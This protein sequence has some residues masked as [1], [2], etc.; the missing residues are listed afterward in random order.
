MIVYGP[1]NPCLEWSTQGLHVADG[2]HSVSAPVSR[3]RSR[4]AAVVLSHRTRRPSTEPKWWWEPASVRELVATLT[5]VQRDV[6]AQWSV[7][8]QSRG[9]KPLCA[10]ARA[11][12]PRGGGDTQPRRRRAAGWR[13]PGRCRA[14]GWRSPSCE[15]I[16]RLS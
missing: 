15:R 3:F 12:T 1:G 10:R 5:R 2:G 4:M 13:R 8:I 7:A 14:P 6:G 16:I 11:C 9:R